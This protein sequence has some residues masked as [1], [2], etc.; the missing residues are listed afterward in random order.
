MLTFTQRIKTGME[1]NVKFISKEYRKLNEKLHRA[2]RGFGGD[3]KKWADRVDFLIQRFGITTLLDY[4][5]G[6]STLWSELKK[7]YNNSGIIRYYEY[8]PCVPGKTIVPHQ[9]V[10]M[11]VCTDVLEHVEPEFLENVITHIHNLALKV[12]FLNINIHLANKV[13]PDGRNAH[14]TIQGRTWW[15]NM[16]GCVFKPDNWQIVEMET[17]RPDKDYVLFL[18]RV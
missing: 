16:L 11:V 17:K 5:C 6:Q 7:K 14:L 18:K 8:D 13:L 3:G 4:G 9:K 12:V 1:S 2:P 15:K 10:D